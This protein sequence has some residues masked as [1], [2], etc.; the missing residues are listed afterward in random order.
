MDLK[1]SERLK[2]QVQAQQEW[3]QER[4][5]GQTFKKRR[6]YQRQNLKGRRALE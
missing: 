2:G 6:A 5:R 1:V 3:E 4:A